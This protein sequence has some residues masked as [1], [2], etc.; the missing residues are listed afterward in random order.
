MDIEEIR[1]LIEKSLSPNINLID[2]ELYGIHYG[3]KKKK[4]IKKILMT[5][6]LSLKAI[7]YAIKNKINL[8]ISF[9]GLIHKPII[10]FNNN[11]INKLNLLSKYPISIFILNSSLISAEGGISDIISELLFLKLEHTFNIMNFN[12]LEIPIGRICSPKFYTNEREDLTLNTLIKR[13]KQNYNIDK[14]IYVGELN[15]VLKKICIIGGELFKI[16]YLEKASKLGCDCFISGKI[17][18]LGASYANDIGIC[19]IKIPF[20]ES[21]CVA[22]KKLNNILSLEYPN[23]EFVFFQYDNPIQVFK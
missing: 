12:N 22:L 19:I 7:H 23:E 13:I 9:Y 16:D 10:M 2:N 21:L 3:D 8:I 5:V 17:N 4:N 20:Y 14:I 18:F 1:Q 6:D 15:K 11:L